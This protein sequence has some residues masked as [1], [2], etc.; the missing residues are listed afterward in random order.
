M[1]SSKENKSLVKKGGVFG[2]TGQ[3]WMNWHFYRVVVCLITFF[4]LE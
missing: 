4:E 1:N 2:E 3:K